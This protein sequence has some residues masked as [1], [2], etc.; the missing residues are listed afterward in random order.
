MALKWHA[1]INI[2]VAAKFLT[3]TSPLQ[4]ILTMQRLQGWPMVAGRM[5]GSVILHLPS[6]REDAAVRDVLQGQTL[7]A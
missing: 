7:W 4:T 1:R 5:H 3:V 6:K 2:L